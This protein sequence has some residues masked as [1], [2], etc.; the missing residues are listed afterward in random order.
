MCNTFCRLKLIMMCFVIPI[1]LAGCGA[2]PAEDGKPTSNLM[3]LGISGFL[4]LF[5]TGFHCVYYIASLIHSGTSQ[6]RGTNAMSKFLRNNTSYKRQKRILIRSS[7]L[8]G[9]DLLMMAFGFTIPKLIITLLPIGIMV[10][11]GF[12]MKKGTEDKER[13]KATRTVTKAAVT[14][15]AKTAVVGGTVV[16]AAMTAPVVAAAVGAGSVGAAAAT[17]TAASGTIAAAGAVKHLG[18]EASMGAERVHAH[19]EDVDSGREVREFPELS[20]GETIS[21]EE[22][23]EKAVRL[24]C[25]QQMSINEMA[26]TILKY[27]PEASINELPPDMDDVEKAARLVG[28][29]KSIKPTLSPPIEDAQY[30][31]VK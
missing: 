1:L 28:A 17:L 31:E 13:E 14:A 10:Y 25:T 20:D 9:F 30:R 15:G 29:V 22:F 11:A 2:Q 6:K 7:F 19:M 8:V 16:G 12:L 3:K 24:G 26:E 21:P 5:F 23:M 27:A 4:M 18:H